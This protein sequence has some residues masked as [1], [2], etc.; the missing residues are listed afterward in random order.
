[1]LGFLFPSMNNTVSNIKTEV[2]NY[3]S[4]LS[5]NSTELES[6]SKVFQEILNEA[7][8]E[9]S[10]DST[11]KQTTENNF[12]MN[13]NIDG[14]YNK[15]SDISNIFKQDASGNTSTVAG[16]VVKMMCSSQFTIQQKF[17]LARAL[18]LTNDNVNSYVGSQGATID[19][20]SSDGSN[21]NIGCQ[22]T[23]SFGM[24]NCATNVQ[25]VVSNRSEA[26]SLAYLTKKNEEDTHISQKM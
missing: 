3:T 10:V 2:S 26:K 20:Q 17:L 14:I 9:Q 16:K 24:N 5:V 4:N 12:D 23:A 8:N 21:P 19:A 15:G 18:D 1:M 22:K 11:V 13:M 7:D 6:V 25:K